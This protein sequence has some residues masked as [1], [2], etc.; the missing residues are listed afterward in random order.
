MS[1]PRY[2]QYKDSGVEWLGEVPAHWE[3]VRLRNIVEIKKVIAGELGF[4]ILSI[5]QSGIKVKDIE[6]GE[7]QLSMDYTKY[8]VVEIGD[9]AMNSMDLLTG[10]VD[11]ASVKGV[12]SPDYRVFRIIKSNCCASRYLL[13]ILINSYLQKIFFAF[14]QG[15]AQLGR[16]RLPRKEFNAFGV[17]LPPL[18][19]QTAIAEFLDRETGKIDELVAEQ[20]RLIG[21]LK[22]KRQAVISHAVTKGLDPNAPMKYSGVEWLG[23][24]PEHWEVL[25]LKRIVVLQ[26]GNSITSER[27]EEAGHYPVFGGNGLRGFTTDFTHDGD[28]VLIGRQGALCGNINYASGQF[29]ASEHAIVVTPYQKLEIRWLGEFLRTMNLNQY[30]ISAAQPGLSVEIIRNLHAC[31]PPKSEQTAI[32]IFLDSE[33]N[34][35]DSLITEAER[36]IS[37]L[38]ERRSALISAA[39]TG[40]IDVRAVAE[41]GAA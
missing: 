24:V 14:G 30:S 4:E 15:S 19:E 37:L 10:G 27:I 35:F 21:L 1:L 23:E 25:P 2:P 34:K 32:S 41:R 6:S 29:W 12:T 16:W 38:Q 28:F 8:Q 26:S 22:E 39:V 36:A 33:L 9:F 40:Q 5:T 18:P 11:I 31:L 3:V 20:R 17:P 13:F 7:G